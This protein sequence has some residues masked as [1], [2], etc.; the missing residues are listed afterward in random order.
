[1]MTNAETYVNEH[2]EKRKTVCEKCFPANDDKAAY[3]QDGGRG[4]F[5]LREGWEIGEEGEWWECAACNHHTRCVRRT[6]AKKRQRRE[7]H[8]AAK[9]LARELGLLPDDQLDD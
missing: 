5:Y 4:I 2:P 6:T 9:T 8:N 1:M 3:L 7:E